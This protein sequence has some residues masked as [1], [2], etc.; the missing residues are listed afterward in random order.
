MRLVRG[1]GSRPHWWAWTPFRI[2]RGAGISIEATSE[3]A[4]LTP[5]WLRAL[6]KYYL[7]QFANGSK[8]GV[9]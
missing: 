2:P 3:A 5:K 4:A 6:S 8:L 9:A 7:E 1:S